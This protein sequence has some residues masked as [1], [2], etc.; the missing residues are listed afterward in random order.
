MPRCY[1][2]YV[3]PAGSLRFVPELHIAQ[4]Q[5]ADKLV[6]QDPLAL[7]IAM[8]LDQQIGIQTTAGPSSGA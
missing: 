5:E 8:V 3:L 7:L 1:G 4:H 2:G 6:S